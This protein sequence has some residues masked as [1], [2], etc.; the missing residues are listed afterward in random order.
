MSP[1]A[2]A[3]ALHHQCGVRAVVPVWP[4]RSECDGLSVAS[5]IV[6]PL[7][8]LVGGSGDLIGTTREVWKCAEAYRSDHPVFVLAAFVIVYV[9][10]QTFAIPGPIV[11]SI[12]SGALYPR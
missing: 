12:L 10:F 7:P 2:P 5:I 8:K 4:T 3:P 1:H 11:L 9:L 6:K